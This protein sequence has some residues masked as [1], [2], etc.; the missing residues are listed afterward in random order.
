MVDKMNSQCLGM[1]SIE[2]KHDV[3]IIYIMDVCI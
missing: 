1:N 2:K 3:Q